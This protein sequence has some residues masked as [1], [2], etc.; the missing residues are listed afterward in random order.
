MT[1]HEAARDLDRIYDA[2][3]DWYVRHERDVV[4]E[5]RRTCG[6]AV[7]KPSGT[8]ADDG[9]ERAPPPLPAT[10]A[11]CVQETLPFTV[12]RPGC[13]VRWLLPSALMLE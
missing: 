6:M 3:D 7:Q 12:Y 13:R 5:H 8:S 2:V 9:A 11:P 4:G 1:L 10:T